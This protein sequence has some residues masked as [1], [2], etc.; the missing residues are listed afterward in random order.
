MHARPRWNGS[1]L[2]GVLLAGALLDARAAFAQEETLPAWIPS[3]GI[4][5]GIHSRA[6]EGTVDGLMKTSAVGPNTQIPC[7]LQGFCLFYDQDERN[8]DG[9]AVGVSAQLLGPSAPTWPLRPRP[10]VQAALIRPF[11]SRVLAESGY[12]PSDF[13]ANGQEPDLQLELNA[14]P[15]LLWYTGGGA[16]LQLPFERPVFIK[17]GAHYMEERLDMLGRIQRNVDNTTP[18][19]EGRKKEELTV[20]SI[21]PDIGLEVEVFRFG[22]FAAQL[23][24][25]VLLS[26]PLNSLADTFQADQPLTP[27]EIQQI[28]LG[29]LQPPEPADFTYDAE[30]VHIFG[31][32]WIRFAWLGR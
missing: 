26:F 32:V 2:A 21:G 7:D 20:R 11:A 27:A 4:G 22:P 25:D 8:I 3:V 5:P 6:A 10:F 23:S 14:D 29:L 15:Q 12:Q 19:P 13:D 31:T 30:N 16:A 24:A 28:E 18:L 17:L 9:T 1:L